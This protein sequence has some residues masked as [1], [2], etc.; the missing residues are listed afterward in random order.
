MITKIL[1]NI[2]KFLD[3]VNQWFDEQQKCEIMNVEYNLETDYIHCIGWDG[4]IIYP[5]CG[6]F[7]LELWSEI[8]KWSRLTKFPYTL[9]YIYA[10]ND[11]KH[12]AYREPIE[13]YLK[14]VSL[15]KT[16][17]GYHYG[18]EKVYKHNLM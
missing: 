9:I 13:D 15:L 2:T 1:K 18:S 7:S 14:D 5:F 8:T 10:G 3:K 17:N 6:K 16:G 12:L 11:R 4:K